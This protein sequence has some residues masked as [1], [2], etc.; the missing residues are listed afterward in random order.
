MKFSMLRP[1][2]PKL[3]FQS[4]ISPSGLVQAAAATCLVAAAFP[5]FGQVNAAAP[6]ETTELQE[7]VVTGSRIAVPGNVTATSPMTI[8][9]AQDIQQQGHT[10]IT[11]LINQLPQNFINAGA[12]LGNTSNPLS[13]AGGIATVDLRG[14]GPQRTLVLVDGRRLGNGDP[15]TLNPNPAAD[16][17][18]IPAAMVERIDVVTGGASAVY[19][20]DAIAGVVNFILKKNFQGVQIDGQYGFNQHSNHDGFMQENESADGIVPPTGNTTNG[21]RRDIS[22]VMGT[23][24]AD[25]QGNITAYFNFHHQDPVAG[26]RY[27]YADCLFQFQVCN[28]SS[29]S[30]RFTIGGNDYSVVGN[31]FLPYPAAGSV[32]P[33]TFNSSAYE[34]QQREDDRYQAGFLSHLD[35]NEHVKPY[36]DFSFMDDKTTALVAPSGLFRGGNPSTADNNY[37][38]NCGNPFLSAQQLGVVQAGGFCGAGTTATDQFDVNIGRRNIEGGGRTSLFDHTNYRV[39]GGATG[40]IIDGIT[41]DAYVQYYYTSLYSANG[42]YIS[43]AGAEN[44]LNVVGTAAAPVCVSGGSCV[45]WNIFNQGGV[46]PAALAYL[47]EPGTSFGTDTEKIWHADVTAELGKFGVKSP[48]ANDGAAVNVGWEHRFEGLSY[49]P[50]QAE[51]SGDLSGYSGAAPPISAGYTVGEAF[52]EARLPVAQDLPGIVDLDID[53]GY[54][55]SHYTT[56]G[57]TNTYKL[58]I[59]YQ[60]IKDVRLRGSFDRAVRAPNLIELYNPQSYG[61]QSFVGVD[62]C[63]PTVAGGAPSATLIECQRTG[64]T[65]AQYAAA[66]VGIQCTANQCGQVTGGSPNLKPEVAV[67]WSTGLSFTP[68]FLPNFLATIDYYHIALTGEIGVIPGNIIFNNCLNTGN[69][70]YCSQIVRNPVTGALHG[71]T[72]AGG[73][74][75]LQ[76]SI[77]TGAS[78]VSGIDLGLNYKYPLPAAGTLLW[79]MNGTWVQHT[80]TTPYQGAPTYDCAHLF[81]ENCGNGIN[82][83]WRHTMRFTWDTPW[84]FELSAFWRFIG[85]TSFDNNST[86]SL[87]AG[88]EEGAYDPSHARIPGYN[89]LDLTATAH[90]TSNVD[91]RVGVQNLFDK[92]PPLLPSEIQDGSQNN[93]FLAYDTLGRQLFASF[94]AKF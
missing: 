87:L 41:Y 90:V 31:Q 32:P 51:L 1:S 81:G 25:G 8:I 89:Y 29:N 57:T 13:S 78:I 42:G 14:L 15:N 92:D 58:E 55:Y 44:A 82:P 61:E 24:V 28:N 21:Y 40:D 69:P 66:N 9:S 52:A 54:R 47:S 22:V 35:I 83:S 46:T 38:V 48:I 76:T 17:D 19:G 59:Q 73:G 6:A 34:Y 30:N 72:V 86:N 26:S 23:N 64:M 5:V 27:D 70:E 33:A 60:P 94:T 63:A 3:A 68:T 75:I 7:V 36:L 85:P 11:D 4:L 2:G 62:P 16:L 18:Q 84:R 49:A 45:P 56:A 79:S 88:A 10:D 65:A 12:D 50:D 43:I 20:S 39:V 71:A 93:T 74:Y 80:T 77:N 53:A 67:T 91:V 37:L